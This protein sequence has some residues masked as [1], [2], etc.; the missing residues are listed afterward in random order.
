MLDYSQAANSA[1]PSL[2]LVIVQIRHASS[3]LLDA[4]D[5]HKQLRTRLESLPDSTVL[6]AQVSGGGG[7]GGPSSSVR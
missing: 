5:E 6:A 4:L 1:P 2:G 3:K 7:G